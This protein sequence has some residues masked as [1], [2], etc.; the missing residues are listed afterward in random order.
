MSSLQSAPSA[1][2]QRQGTFVS[3]QQS[4]S[5]FTA[6]LEAAGLLIRIKDE[7]R[8]D[9]LPLLM[10]KYPTKAVLVEKIAGCEFSFL[11]NAYATH[12]QF[13]F[14]LGCK[15]NEIGDRIAELAKGRI[16]PK[17]VTTAPCKEVILK[18]ADVDLSRLPLFLHHDRDGHAYTAT[19]SS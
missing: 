6:D 10:E 4:L 11:A 12:E 1:R 8:V 7:K 9:Q 17:I 2:Q 18:G 13:A 3:R 5:D 19:T 14:A 16:K 15:R